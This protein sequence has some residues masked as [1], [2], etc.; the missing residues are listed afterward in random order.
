MEP[1]SPG[2]DVIPRHLTVFDGQQLLSVL[3]DVDKYCALAEYVN[4]RQ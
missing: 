2:L 1:Q 3:T 4:P